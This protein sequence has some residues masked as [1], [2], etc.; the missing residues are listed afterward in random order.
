MKSLIITMVWANG[1][2]IVTISAMDINEEFAYFS[3]WANPPVDFCYPGVS[4]TSTWKGGGYNT[5]SGTSMAAPHAAGI[6][7]STNGGTTT[8][9]TVI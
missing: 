9:G 3:N 7:L 8:D 1:Q 4:I 6:L 5:I 2:Y